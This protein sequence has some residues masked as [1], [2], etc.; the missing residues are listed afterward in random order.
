MQSSVQATDV[1]MSRAQSLA[2]TGDLS[3]AAGVLRAI[4]AQRAAH[5]PALFMLG[6]IEAQLRQFGDAEIHLTRAVK[7]DPRSAEALTVLG[8]V[9][10]ELKRHEEAVTALT[11]ALTFQ[12]QNGHALLYRGLAFAETGKHE[13]AIADFEKILK[14]DPRSI[15]AL[16]NRATSLMALKRHREARP[17][18]VALVRIAPDYVPALV[19]FVLLLLDDSKY[20]EAL[21]TGDRA[22]R[23]EPRNHDLMHARGTALMKLGRHAE[24][25]AA[26]EYV[27]RQ[28]PDAADA[29]LN[30]ANMLMELG[31]LEESLQSCDA[32]IAAQKVYA[33]GHLMRANVLQHLFRPDEAFAAYDAAIAA[34][35]DYHDAYYHRGSAHLLHGRYKEGWRDFEHRWQASACG[36][37]RPKLQPAEWRGEDLKGRSIV[38][39]AEQGLGDTIQFVR[40]LPK[41]ADMGAKVTF[42]CHPSLMRL[43][44]VF[45][46]RLEI[47]ATVLPEQNFDFQCALMSVAERLQIDRDHLPGPTP[48]LFAEPELVALWREKIG[49]D[50]FKIGIAWQGNPK[51]LID[52]GR[53]VPLAMFEPL[54]HLDGVRLISLQKTHGLDQLSRLPSGMNVETLESFDEGPDGFLDTAAVMEN[55]DL[56]VSSDTATPH[57][58]GALNRPCWVALK[59]VPDWRWMMGRSDSP[60]YPSMRLF[61]QQAAGDWAGVFAEITQ[62]L[63]SYRAE[64]AS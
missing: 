23:I 28:K 51:G 61:R 64:T 26:F 24:A 37:D 50:G 57:L 27:V 4:L 10:T 12:P 1:L 8:S 25:L 6:M 56:V 15:F 42:L 7:I 20:S 41:L 49:G 58:A 44:G 11:R 52:K 38:V 29:H 39:Y 46:D 5:F 60:W 16:H 30:T 9:L 18:V 2:Q 22:L 45:A 63:R 43:F 14:Q 36:F 48:Y 34:K 32:S 17:D 59:Q 35:P 13:R 31:R 3:G 40:F 19:N 21:E 62:A 47:V 55:L 54:A 33:P 53:S